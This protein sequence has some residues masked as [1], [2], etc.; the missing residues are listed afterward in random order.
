MQLLH[1]IWYENQSYSIHVYQMHY[2]LTYLSSS[3][4][5]SSMKGKKILL[6]VHIVIRIDLLLWI[7]FQHDT[8]ECKFW[9]EHHILTMISTGYKIYNWCFFY[10]K[11]MLNF[12][13]LDNF[14]V[15]KTTCQSFKQRD[16]VSFDHKWH[17]LP[18]QKG[19]R[20]IMDLKKG[21]Q[22]N[23]PFYVCVCILCTHEQ[24]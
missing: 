10:V 23:I 24:R 4:L 2:S 20:F 7:Y 11:E 13:I 14:M 21:R 16:N 6:L 18:W 5:D 22:Y 8:S 15:R 12:Y 17:Q 1:K 19:S 3:G 9:H